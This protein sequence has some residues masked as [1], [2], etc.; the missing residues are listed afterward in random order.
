MPAANVRRDRPAWARVGLRWRFAGHCGPPFGGRLG[1]HLQ[2][3]CSRQEVSAALGGLCEG[4][5]TLRA[6]WQLLLLR[7]T[8]GVNNNRGSLIVAERQLPGP[9]AERYRGAAGRRSCPRAQA[10]AR[11][12]PRR[13]RRAS[14]LFRAPLAGVDLPG[15]RAHARRLRHPPR[16]ILGP[17]RHRG[18]PPASPKPTS[19]RHWASSAQDWWRLLDGLERRGL[20]RRQPLSDRPPL[21]R[22]LPHRHRGGHP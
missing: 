17:G 12:R 19:A 20:T 6:A 11:A 8:D 13:A 5:L 22:A 7:T 4:P 21:A 1:P 2:Y 3:E 10:A 14:R 18:Q 9:L 15:L 16:A